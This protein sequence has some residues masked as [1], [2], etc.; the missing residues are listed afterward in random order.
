MQVLGNLYNLAPSADIIGRVSIDHTEVVTGRNQLVELVEK[1]FGNLWTH[2]L[3]VDSDMIFSI[4]DLDK[5]LSPR[6]PIISGLAVKRFPPPYPP[7][8][9]PL[10]GNPVDFRELFESLSTPNPYPIP[11]RATGMAFTLIE[12]SVFERVVRED[13]NGKKYWFAPVHEIDEVLHKERHL[14]EDFAFCKRAREV[15]IDTYIHPGVMLGH[16]NYHALTI[17]D[18]FDETGVEYETAPTPKQ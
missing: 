18:W 8:F 16:L 12:R 6:L 14:S 9:M 7:A 5:L 4:M 11:V 10:S 2:I 3:F 15:G 17:T 13:H 1:E